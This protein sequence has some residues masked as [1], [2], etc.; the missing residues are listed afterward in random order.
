MFVLAMSEC[1]IVVYGQFKI[2]SAAC[3]S[4]REQ[5]NCQWDD[6]EV[7]F[8]LGQQAELDL[9]SASLLKQRSAGR[10]VAPRWHII[11]NQSQPFLALSP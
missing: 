2:F 7:R 5:V 11:L 10:H 1:V 4:W 6:E 8:V 3:M 9:Y